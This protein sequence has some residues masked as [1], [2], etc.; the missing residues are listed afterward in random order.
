MPIRSGRMTAV[1]LIRGPQM[2]EDDE[3]KRK[4]YMGELISALDKAAES[5]SEVAKL[6]L[7]RRRNMVQAIAEAA[8]PKFDEQRLLEE[9][10]RELNSAKAKWVWFWVL[11]IAGVLLREY[12]NGG[13][14]L[15]LLLV[16]GYIGVSHV[17]IAFAV[18]RDL[19][20][21]KSAI[22]ELHF[23]WH[24][25]GGNPVMLSRLSNIVQTKGDAFSRDTDE[26][27]VWAFEA[28]ADLLDDILG[29]FNWK[30]P[31]SP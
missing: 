26:F 27:R 30:R 20:E 17:W 8:L 10:S 24:A 2:S 1:R 4:A 11:A 19:K 6:E 31:H 3:S 16:A 28:Q 23:R 18:E 21:L 12:F 5:L 14:G 9:Q 7:L 13:F 15:A 29:L 25:N 22:R